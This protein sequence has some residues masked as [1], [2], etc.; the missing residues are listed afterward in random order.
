MRQEKNARRMQPSLGSHPT[1]PRASPCPS[2]DL[3][4]PTPMMSDPD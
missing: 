1:L 4:L 2:L 3:S